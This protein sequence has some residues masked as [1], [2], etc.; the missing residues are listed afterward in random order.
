MRTRATEHQSLRAAVLITVALLLCVVGSGC[1]GVPRLYPGVI[2][3]T[4]EGAYVL[5]VLWLRVHE[6]P[7]NRRAAEP[8][9]GREE[10]L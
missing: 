10:A 9:S 7:Q 5:D 4:A 8:Q 1:C 2:I 3:T 6:E